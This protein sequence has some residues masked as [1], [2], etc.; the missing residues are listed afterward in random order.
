MTFKTEKLGGGG[1]GGEVVTA[2]DT[3]TLPQGVWVVGA[4]RTSGTYANGPQLNGVD[5]G[6]FGPELGHIVFIAPEGGEITN[7]E[8]RHTV[9]YTCVRIG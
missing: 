9:I 7:P 1:G 8:T 3:V 5:V 6:E 2:T 4:N